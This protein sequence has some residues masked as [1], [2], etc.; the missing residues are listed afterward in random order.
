MDTFQ[1]LFNV[2][3]H[4]D[5]TLTVS[6]YELQE[7]VSNLLNLRE[8]PIKNSGKEFPS[9]TCL[10][11]ILSTFFKCYQVILR[12]LCIVMI[13]S[14]HKIIY[15][16]YAMKMVHFAIVLLLLKQLSLSY[17]EIDSEFNDLQTLC[18]S[19]YANYLILRINS[20]FN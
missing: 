5:P 12:Q 18:S 15:K 8:V 6:E 13:L 11:K 16:I 17:K 14:A 1:Y 2:F 20:N 10:G 9:E 4:L 3:R 7:F 19:F